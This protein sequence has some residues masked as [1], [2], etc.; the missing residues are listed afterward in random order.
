MSVRI[1]VNEYFIQL[2]ADSEDP[3]L[4]RALLAIPEIEKSRRR[5]TY[6]CSL[7]KLPELLKILR[8]IEASNQITVEAV[9]T[10][11]DEETRRRSQTKMLKDLGPDMTSDWLW[12]HQCL[13]IELAQVNRRFNFYYDTRTGKTLM[14]LKILYDR[15]KAGLARR[16]LVICPPS[17]VPAWIEDAEKHFPE[18]K[19]AAYYGTPAM[20]AKALSQPA[21][22]IIWASSMLV[23]GLDQLKQIDFHTCIFDE[24]SKIKN[25]RTQISKAALELSRTIPSWYNLSATPAPNGEDEYYIQMRCLDP[26]V[27]HSARSHFVSR[28]FDNISRSY[29]YEKL[30]L[31]EHMRRAFLDTVEDYSLYVDQ[32]VMPTAGKEWHIVP[33]NLQPKTWEM[34]N[35][36]RSNMLAE[37][38]DVVI[39]TDMAA[40]MRSKLNQIT[41][42]F[43]IDTEA[44]KKN[45]ANKLIGETETLPEIYRLSDQSRI[46]CLTSLLDTLRPSKA[47]IWAN[48]REEFKMLGEL[49]GDDARFIHGGTSTEDREDYIYNQFKQGSLRYLVCHPLSVGMGINL[50]ESHIAIYYSLNDSWEAFKQSSERIYGH[51]NV[52]PNKCHYYILLATDTVNEMIYKNLTGKRDASTGFLEHLKGGSYD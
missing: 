33:F 41:S 3:N 52:Q 19:I 14:C 24:S 38:E 32:S 37:I 20:R 22:I 31:K 27:F 34:Y 13:G 42:G 7:R 6:F 23:K 17:I 10:L 48:Y 15:L 16:C 45:E 50:S 11:Y 26:Y 39:T 46:A 29:Q 9:R 1:F 30:V 40:S 12:P 2:N 18:L 43:L 28:Y 44:K 21:H 51:I 35:Q 36:M 4:H 47:V 8:G 25:Y 5:D 49:L